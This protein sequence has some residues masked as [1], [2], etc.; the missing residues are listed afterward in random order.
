MRVQGLILQD[1]FGH[2]HS[3]DVHRASTSFGQPLQMAFLSVSAEDSL[4]WMYESI[5]NFI[6]SLDPPMESSELDR[7]RP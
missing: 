3:T 5:L 7:T 2:P 4:T 1:P 6:R